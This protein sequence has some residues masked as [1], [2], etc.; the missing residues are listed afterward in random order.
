MSTNFDDILDIGVDFNRDAINTLVRC[1]YVIN[2]PSEFDHADGVDGL[3]KHINQTDKFIDAK[4]SNKGQIKAKK[5]YEEW[6]KKKGFTKDNSVSISSQLRSSFGTALLATSG[7][8]KLFVNSRLNEITS[9]KN[10]TPSPD[11]CAL[12]KYAEELKVKNVDYCIDSF[13][14]CDGPVRHISFLKNAIQ[15]RCEGEF[16]G[17]WNYVIDHEVLDVLKEREKNLIVF[18]HQEWFKHFSAIFGDCS[19]WFYTSS[20]AIP[21]STVLKFD[22]VVR[23]DGN[24]AFGAPTIDYM[25]EPLK[26]CHALH[27]LGRGVRHAKKKIL[28]TAYKAD[29]LKEAHGKLNNAYK[30]VLGRGNDDP[31]E[32][33]E[34]APAAES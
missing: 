26:N 5:L 14:D 27:K 32:A 7:K 22:I 18:G 34:E 17:F 6:F 24:M 25:Q 3:T 9:S 29:K 23:K 13:T 1:Y 31:F 20:V 12:K 19:R 8:D 30:A 28:V 2:S 21:N 16:G 15:T 11:M 10:A 4:L 33:E